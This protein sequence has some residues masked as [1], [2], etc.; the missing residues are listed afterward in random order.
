[1]ICNHC[2]WV[3]NKEN[4]SWPLILWAQ[5]WLS[6]VY[7]RAELKWGIARNKNPCRVTPGFHTS[8][9]SSAGACQ[10]S[11]RSKWDQHLSSGNL[12]VTHLPSSN[13]WVQNWLEVSY[14]FIPFFLKSYL[15]IY[16]SLHLPQQS[17]SSQ[18]QELGLNSTSWFS[19]KYQLQCQLR[20]VLFSFSWKINKVQILP[21]I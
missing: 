12:S 2:S 3:C 16:L 13:S 19:P 17:V 9:N 14:Y 11:W 8:S 15:F 18:G 10:C 1:M 5:S 20:I 7:T 4:S 21:C 6:E